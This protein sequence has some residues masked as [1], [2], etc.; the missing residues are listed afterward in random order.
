MLQDRDYHA[1]LHRAVSQ[2]LE[3]TSYPFSSSIWN[4]QNLSKNSNKTSNHVKISQCQPLFS[5]YNC[6][7]LSLRS[8]HTSKIP[9]KEESVVEK[10]VKSLKEKS[11]NEKPKVIPSEE[12]VPTAAKPSLWQRIVAEFKHYYHGF[13][14][15]FLEIRLS[16]RYI[17]TVM[18]G[19][20]LTRRE[21]KQVKIKVLS[22]KV[23]LFI[24]FECTI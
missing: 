7:Y 20:T 21:R 18:D 16:W 13:R 4:D 1:R 15:F 17:K 22:L 14:L 11:E 6:Q 2:Q 23:C 3:I 19:Q 10:S 12:T 5:L 9:Y 24:N 8:F